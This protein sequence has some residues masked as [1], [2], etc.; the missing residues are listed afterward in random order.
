MRGRERGS[1]HAKWRARREALAGTI[2]DLNIRRIEERVG[3]VG[4]A[5]GMD[6]DAGLRNIVNRK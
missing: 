1:A 5:A 2:T 6:H 4:A 3:V